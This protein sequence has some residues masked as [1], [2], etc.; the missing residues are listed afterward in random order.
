MLKKKASNND[1]SQPSNAAPSQQDR[2]PAAKPL[3]LQDSLAAN[4]A[5]QNEIFQNM[6][7]NREALGQAFA[8]KKI[9]PNHFFASKDNAHKVLT[10]IGMLL[11]GMGGGIKHQENPAVKQI[12]AAINND[13]EAQKNDQSN[14]MNLWKMNH[15]ALQDESAA[16]MQSRNALLQAAKAQIDQQ[17]G[18]L[19][20][21]MASLRA[22]ALKG[23]LDNEIKMNDYKTSYL[24]NIQQGTGQTADPAT[25]LNKRFQMG[26]ITKDQYDQGN[27]ELGTAQ[28]SIQNENQN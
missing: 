2:T 17:Q 18:L 15:M 24:K 8:D 1:Q 23:Q 6:Q 13:I 19:P 21:S 12:N 14:T 25:E 16:N 28:E 9:D 20:G 10:G 22:Q 5:R 26:L 27:K 3:S 11:G 4:Q 7:A